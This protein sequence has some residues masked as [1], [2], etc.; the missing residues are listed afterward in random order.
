MD[1]QQA[2]GAAIAGVK[3]EQSDFEKRMVERLGSGEALEKPFVVKMRLIDEWS[4]PIKL[5]LCLQIEQ[6]FW[7][8][9]YTEN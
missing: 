3:K 1:G 8:L 7:H 5:L 9:E 6:Q 2:A 4:A